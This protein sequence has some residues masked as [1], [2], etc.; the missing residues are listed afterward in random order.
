MEAVLYAEV[1]LICMIV[2][3][4]LLFWMVR[5]KAASV[6]ERWIIWLL[7][8][9]LVN[10]TSNFFFT[11]LNGVRISDTLFIP[12]SY[13]FKTL[14]H[15]SLCVGVFIW[16]GY[17]ETEL[18]SGLFQDRSLVRWL[19]LPLAVPVVPAIANL[20]TGWLFTI[21]ESGEYVRHLQFQLEM[22]YLVLWSVVCGFRLLRRA[23]RETDDV[24]KAHLRLTATFALCLI[25]AWLLSFIGEE[26]PVI[27][28]LVMLDL[29]WL[30]LANLHQQIS[31]D[32]LTQV[33]NRQNLVG[34]LEYKIRNHDET[35]FLL[36][37]DVDG[38]KSINDTYGHLEGDNALVRVAGSLKQACGAFRRRPYIAR[39]GGDEFI[40]AIEGSEEDVA[41]LRR[42]IEEALASGGSGREPYELRLSMGAA[43]WQ[44]DMSFRDLIGAADAELYK[45][46][47]SR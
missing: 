38:F 20:W 19:L 11:L 13:C 31:M 41:E 33:N 10:F 14:Y 4:L 17:A 29:L 25:A 28:V 44:P 39:Y 16:C 18:H 3:G 12:G 24:R 22:G 9:F 21:S 7:L 30:Y 15:V 8:A 32:K 46:K 26:I 42:R 45:H 47:K 37:L 36:M 27:C 40:I 5:N 2:L 35:L 43:A 1:Y 34:F 6:S 23:D